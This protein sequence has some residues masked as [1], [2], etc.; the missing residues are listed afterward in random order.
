MNVLDEYDKDL[1]DEREYGGMEQSAR[2]AAEREL[3]DRD[4]REGRGRGRLGAAEASDEEDE[5]EEDGEGFARR[6]KRRRTMEAAADEAAEAYAE[7]RPRCLL[8]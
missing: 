4:R 5:D 7:V 6:Q 2:M 3:E 8:C 1:L